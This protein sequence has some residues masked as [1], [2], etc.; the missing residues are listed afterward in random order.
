MIFLLGY[1]TYILKNDKVE[2]KMIYMLF[3]LKLCSKL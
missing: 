1:L 3:V 2:P